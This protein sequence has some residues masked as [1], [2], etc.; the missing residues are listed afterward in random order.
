M[1]AGGW[2]ILERPG[3][4]PGGCHHLHRKHCRLTGGGGMPLPLRPIVGA[5]RGPRVQRR[6]WDVLAAREKGGAKK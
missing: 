1:L 4:A 2:A 3:L 5:T 6:R